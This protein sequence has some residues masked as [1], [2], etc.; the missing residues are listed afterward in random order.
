MVRSHKVLMPW[1][2]CLELSNHSEIQHSPQQCCPG[3]CPISMTQSF[4]VF[5]DVRL[6][7]KQH[8]NLKYKFCSF[9][10]SQDCMIRLL[11][12]YCTE[13][14]LVNGW[15]PTDEWTHWPLE[16]LNNFREVI[17]K[18]ISDGWGISCK[19]ALRWMP[20]DLTDDK[21]TLVR[22]MAWCRQA[23]S[24]YLSQ[25][26]PR[27]IA[28]LGHY[29]LKIFTLIKHHNFGLKRWRTN[30]GFRQDK[31][32]HFIWKHWRIQVNEGL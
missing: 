17:F 18:L 8:D 4:D 16:D 30:S 14:Y 20:L 27:S 15:C 32:V 22:V 11:I 21:S 19:I 5:F 26:W 3:T 28:S 31:F 7:K 23:T 12:R 25:C 29:E 9:K 10:I 1:D 6:Q 24:H 2:L 13:G